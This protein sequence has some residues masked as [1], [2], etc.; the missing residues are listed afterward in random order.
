MKRFLPVVLL[1]LGTTPVLADRIHTKAGNV[2]EGEI[3]DNGGDTVDVKVSEK[4]IV[5]VKRTDIA[6]IESVLSPEQIAVAKE[7]DRL[8]L[9]ASASAGRPEVRAKDVAA[10]ARLDRAIVEPLLLKKL[11]A[12]SGAL[13]QRKL[14]AEL[15]ATHTNEESI[16]GLARSVVLDGASA[17]RSQ[18]MTSL[19]KIGN[20][21]TGLLFVQAM[22]RSDPKERTRAIA[23]LGTF[24]RKEAVAAMMKLGP[25]GASSSDSNASR[26]YIAVLTQRAYISGY[27]L[28]SGGT[29]LRVAEVAQPE[30]NVLSEGVVL[31][32]AVRYIVEYET[33]VRGSVFSFLT[34][35]SFSSSDQVA[36]WWK[37][38]EKGFELAPEAQKQ[39]A[40]LGAPR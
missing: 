23:A 8:F 24:P 31:E 12:V 30:I 7:A 13:E 11:A 4:T 5:R 27:T 19:R 15:L 9:E 2:V 37:D 18:A 22:T 16:R 35:K 25:A 39:L 34:G 33:F 40:S 28:S 3:T 36:A 32:V 17:V 14:A 20:P 29:G 38:A 21:D 1:L 26:C 10:F 6:R